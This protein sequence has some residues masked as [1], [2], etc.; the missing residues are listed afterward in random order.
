MQA[1]CTQGCCIN[2][3]TLPTTTAVKAHNSYPYTSS[4]FLECSCHI[5][6]M[7]YLLCTF[8]HEILIVY[9]LILTQG[10]CVESHVWYS[11]TSACKRNE[12]GMLNKLNDSPWTRVFQIVRQ[13]ICWI[14]QSSTGSIFSHLLSCLFKTFLHWLPPIETW[15]IIVITSWLCSL[16]GSTPKSCCVLL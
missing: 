13:N 15:N 1:Y 11:P 12:P 5:S 9:L 2:T 7:K 10:L 6:Y 14:H 16:M 8:I 4:Q 3:A